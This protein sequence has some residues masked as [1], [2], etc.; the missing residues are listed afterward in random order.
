MGEAVSFDQ[1]VKR[2]RNDRKSTDK[3]PG[4]DPKNGNEHA[5]YLFLLEA[6]GPKGVRTGVISFENPDPSAA[7]FKKQL[8]AASIT[9]QEI[10]IWNVV[11]WYIGNRKGTSIRAATG[12]DV[13]AGLEY[14]TQLISLMPKL[15]CIVL[16]G[17]AARKAHIFLSSITEVRIVSC[18]H[19]SARV[20]NVNPK[21]AIE[22]IEIFRFIKATT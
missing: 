15:R 12:K 8:A 5:K 13:R 19:P 11:P 22:N 3:V 7:N 2:I 6:P 17:G 4:F 20:V 18:H 14:L 21:A 1:L 16:V 9:R 10:A